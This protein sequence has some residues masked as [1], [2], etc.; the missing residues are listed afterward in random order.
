MFFHKNL[1]IVLPSSVKNCVGIL[2][3]IPPNVQ[4]AFR[5]MALS[6]LFPPKHEHKRSF[7][8]LIFLQFLF[9]KDLELLL[10]K[11]FTCFIRFI[12]RYFILF[13]AVVTGVVLLIFP[14]LHLSIIYRRAIGL[15][16]LLLF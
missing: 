2:V 15:L 6:L 8:L 4:I 7:H 9:F 5:R 16:L 3:R 11:Y 14:P 1:R 10:F 12:L 13:E